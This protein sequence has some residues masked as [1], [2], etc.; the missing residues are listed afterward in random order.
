MK[1]S[2]QQPEFF[3]WLGYFD[4]LYQVDKVVFLDNVQFKKR[5][6]ENRNKVRTRDGW[7]WLNT[8][9]KTKGRYTQKIMDAEIDNSKP[10]QK[11]IVSAI[12][13]N[14]RRA[15]YWEYYGE[16]IC[17]IV[18]RPYKFLVD[19]NLSVIL[20]LMEK[21]GVKRE[22]CLSSALSTEDLGSDLILEIC[23]KMQATDYLSGKDG[24]SYL[25]EDGFVK[26]GIKL[27]YQ[28]FIHPVY[29]QFHGGF[30]E[31]MSVIDL[32]FNHGSE[33]TDIIKGINLSKAVNNETS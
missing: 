33:S 13:C 3:P 11:R 24:K 32:L 6:F 10:W 26:N 14:Y 18:S 9:V 25:K 30:F 15:P 19:F 28:N 29:K 1:I 5:Y 2:I 20:F 4:K 23:R 17:G 8:P 7:M 12:R 22:W 27:H 16:S 21:L 31:G